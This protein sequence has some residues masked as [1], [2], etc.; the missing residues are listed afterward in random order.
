M[1]AGE[2]LRARS[3][4]SRARPG[5]RPG[6]RAGGARASGGSG[7]ARSPGRPARER[8]SRR[9]ARRARS[10]RPT[11]AAASRAPSRRRPRRARR[12]AARLPG[13]SSD[14]RSRAAPGPDVARRRPDEPAELLLLE[15]VRRPARRARARE[16][17]GRELRRH[18]GDVE[19]DRRPELD[20][21]LERP[22]GRLLPQRGERGLL[23]LVRDVEARRPELLRRALEQAGAR[24]LG[25]VDA[26]AEAH[27]PLALLDQALT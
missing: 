19:H 4:P 17:R 16:H 11:A 26:V 1:V 20:V 9:P 14:R 7:T 27:Q 13:A 10:P 6:A 18:V 12:P 22:V 8:G 25:A 2:R 3:A 23:E 21:R 5:S 15:D 24:I